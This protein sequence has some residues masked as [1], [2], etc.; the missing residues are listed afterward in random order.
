MTQGKWSCGEYVY[1]VKSG[2]HFGYVIF[3]ILIKRPN[4]DFKKQVDIRI[5]NSEWELKLEIYLNE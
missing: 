3:K 4:V 1:L 5:W 2:F